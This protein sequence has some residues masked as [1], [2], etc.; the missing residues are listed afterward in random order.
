M[1]PEK[2]RVRTLLNSAIREMDLLHQMSEKIE[3]ADDFVT[4][5]TGLVLFRACSMS[6]QYITESFIKIRNIYGSDFFKAYPKI[7][8]NSVF[9][10]RNFLAHEYEEV[11]SE[12]IFGTI[13]YDIPPLPTAPMKR[14]STPSSTRK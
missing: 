1:Y 5:L 9:G 4:T 10:M 13:K 8:W 12:A 6:L 3:N 11:D 14:R 7:P 2:E